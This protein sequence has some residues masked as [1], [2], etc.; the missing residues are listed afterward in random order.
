VAFGLPVPLN[1]ATAEDLSAVPGLTPRVAREIVADR[2]R[3]GRFES[4]ESLL[5]VHGV[6]PRRLDRAREH[7]VAE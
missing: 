4:V 1:A 2:A 6:G 7:L 5:R 3:N